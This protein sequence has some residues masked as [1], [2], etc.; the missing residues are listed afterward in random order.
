MQEISLDFIIA[1]QIGLEKVQK[2]MELIMKS[3][4]ENQL[5]ITQLF[6]KN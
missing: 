5:V 1:Q 2:E 3:I 4:A 6:R